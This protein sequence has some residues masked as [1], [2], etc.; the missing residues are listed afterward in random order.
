MLQLIFVTYEVRTKTAVKVY[1]DTLG[2]RYFA[3]TFIDD[4]PA[5][6]A[7]AFQRRGDATDYARSEV[8]STP[9]T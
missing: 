3:R 2:K 6:Y 4:E 7:K 1:R 5:G 9:C 8:R